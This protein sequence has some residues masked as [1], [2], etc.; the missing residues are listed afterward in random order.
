MKLLT[1]IAE[2]ALE[3][4]LTADLAALGARGWTIVAAHGHGR[5]GDAEG[6]MLGGGNIRIEVIAPPE[7]V[8]AA[9]ARLRD[10]YFEHWGMIVFSHDVEV[11][12]SEKFKG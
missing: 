6:D 11:V 9:V 1:I 2:A 12:R 4:R 7:V 8:A 10:V 3:R 5:H